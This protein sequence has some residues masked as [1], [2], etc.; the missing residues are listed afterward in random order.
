MFGIVD[1]FQL[2]YT[3]IKSYDINIEYIIDLFYIFLIDNIFL[4]Y[5]LF[6]RCD[7]FDTF[8]IVNILKSFYMFLM[9]SIMLIFLIYMT[10]FRYSRHILI[11][12]IFFAWIYD[13]FDFC[14]AH[15]LN[16][17]DQCYI[18]EIF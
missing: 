16:I 9:Q 13:N 7:I 6:L 18:F 8:H 15:N 5:S 1:N 17:F 3:F 10:N 14:I 12:S 2:F 4:I 11:N